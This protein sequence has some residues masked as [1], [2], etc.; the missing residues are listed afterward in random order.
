MYGYEIF[1]EELMSGL[2]SS[3]RAERNSHAYIFEGDPG[4]G[5]HNAAHLFAQA[6]VCTNELM[7]PCCSCEACTLARAGTLDDIKIIEPP[8]DRKFI[9]VESIRSITEDC[10]IK[11][12][13]ARRKVYIINDGALLQ[14]PAQNAFLKTL[15]E[16]PETS[17]FIIIID[18]A[19]RL[20]PTVRSRAVTVSFREISEER[21]SKYIEDKL[22]NGDNT[23]LIARLAFGNP[24]RAENLCAD[25]EY[26]ELREKAY[27]MLERI[28]SSD[29]R[30]AF[31][32][33]EFCETNKEKLDDITDIWLSFLR[34]ILA[35][36]SGA[37]DKIINTDFRERIQNT[38]VSVPAAA[39]SGAVPLLAEMKRRADK[40]VKLRTNVLST[41]LKIKEVRR[42]IA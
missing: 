15:E 41:V 19:S 30:Q 25:G 20:L 31:D 8:K 4:M 29:R 34:D 16:P 33:C 24:E 32:V 38:T 18:T 13:H 35:L 42:M 6:L 10:Y 3:V 5:R 39:V 28:L 17:V 21:I 9:P 2:I 27:D 37:G 14:E 1:H 26:M 40:S 12:D 7:A 11:P 23:E 22:P 36:S